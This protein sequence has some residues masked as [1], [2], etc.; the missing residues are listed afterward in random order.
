MS[1]TNFIRSS[2]PTATKCYWAILKLK[3][4]VH[5]MMPSLRSALMDQRRKP[6]LVRYVLKH[7]LAAEIRKLTLSRIII[8]IC[9][10]LPTNVWHAR[11]HFP[12][13]T[14][15]I[16][17]WSHSAEILQRNCV[18]S[19]ATRNSCG[20]IHWPSTDNTNIL[21]RRRTTAVSFAAKL[22][23]APII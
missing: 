22:S 23:H 14:L 15:Y 8:K 3:M 2:H 20:K 1:T 17:I 18:A 9:Q 7:F 11:N 19:F 16:S 5:Q 6:T 12:T 10:I 21:A 4:N 13:L